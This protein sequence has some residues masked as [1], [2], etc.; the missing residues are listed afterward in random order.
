M[1]SRF[2]FNASAV[3]VGGFLRSGKVVTVVPTIASVALPPTGGEGFASNENHNAHGI[4]FSSASSRVVG[5]PVSETRFTTIAEVQ[6]T[7][8]NVFNRLTVT[9]MKGSIESTRDLHSLQSEFQV[10]LTYA[11]VRLDDRALIPQVDKELCGAATFDA[12]SKLLKK[13]ARIHA[14]RLGGTEKGLRELLDRGATD[15]PL[16]SSAVS[17]IERDEEH[18]G[19]G[20]RLVVPGF[21]TLHFGELTVTASRRRLNLLRIELGNPFEN[22][23]PASPG[24]QRAVRSKSASD[25]RD[26]AAQSKELISDAAPNT[27]VMLLSSTADTT[28]D[29]SITA[30]SVEGNGTPI[31]PDS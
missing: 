12:F 1:A 7:N 23:K 10:S 25:A 31:W 29:G 13:Q 2:S 5:Y 24:R 17:G 27:T 19:A 9:L 15:E 4:S 3:G 16:F 22:E 8:L 14:Q 21:A 28:D 11:G 18:S 20:G 30:G 6:I 26:T